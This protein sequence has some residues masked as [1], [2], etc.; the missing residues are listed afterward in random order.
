MAEWRRTLDSWL[1][2]WRRH[3]WRERLF[4]LGVWLKALDGALELLGGVA[5][6]TVSPAFILQSVQILTQDEI[7]EDPHDLVAN[8]LLRLA[9]GL[10]MARQHFMALYLLVHGVVK[11]ALVWALLKRV[12]MAYPLAILVFATFV[13]Y[14]L[15]RYTLTG[16]LGLLMI[17]AL[18]A[19]VI[20]LVYLEYR[21]LRQRRPETNA[22]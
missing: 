21:A 6:L 10:S 14:Q 16:G 20:A 4:L 3:S 13:A 19:V 17:A 5:L 9:A 11:I 8:A 22:Y 18:D 2:A 12:L 7:V 1:V 15:Y